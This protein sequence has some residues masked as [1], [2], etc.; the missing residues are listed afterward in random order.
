MLKLFIQFEFEK[1]VKYFKTKKLAK[2]ITGSLFLLVFLFIS[3]GIYSFFVTG[4]RYI[5]IES[6]ENIRSS[7]ILFLYEIFLL[8]ISGIIVFSTMI[9]GVFNLFRGGDN[10]W[11]ISSP[12]Y[13]F[14]P[15][16]IFIR[17]LF[18]STLPLIIM[19]IPAVAALVKVYTISYVGVLAILLSVV[20][21]IV[22]LNSLT[23]LSV[24]LV[25]SLYSYISRKIKYI[26][27]NLKGL[28]ILLLITIS[29]IVTKVW[30]AMKSVDLISLFKAKEISGTVSVSNIS[31]HFYLLPTHSF[32]LEILHWQSSQIMDAYVSFFTLFVVSLLFGLLWWNASV[33]FYPLWKKLQ[34][35]GGHRTT[36]NDL[37]SSSLTYRFIGSK[38]M[39]LFKKEL[40]ITSRNYKGVMWFSFLLF[41][42]LLQI[43]ANL[44]L[45]RNIH[46][47]EYDIV[48][49]IVSL[50]LIQYIIAIYFISSFTL[51]FVFPSFSV[52]KKTSWIL[53]SS[54]LSFKKIF[55]GKYFFYTSFFVA[56]GIIMNYINS[57]IL[58]LP[59]THL[60]YSSSLFITAIL[61]IVTL[62]LSLGA[63]FPNTETDDPEVIS[64]SMPGLFFTA[65]ALVY[66]ALSDG[67][68][69]LC[70]SRGMYYIAPLFMLVT[71]LCIVLLI[72]QVLKNKIKGIL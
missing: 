15:K 38:T 7:L 33:V 50:Q 9:T 24:L 2:V 49:K 20:F 60:L 45:G 48:Q 58:K 26:P 55:F 16:L 51:R 37:A 35:E 27:F 72:K 31:D 71:L 8:I 52:E 13:S 36:K 3:I 67:V 69:Y 61:F 54:P 5:N 53:S 25:A 12:K 34:E 39:V 70:L 65:L 44:I 17:S 41:I 32:A 62:G 4:F 59:F 11:I 28:L 63:L 21:L 64:T 14:L 66:G 56:L 22:T 6:E 30:S 42:W 18:N 19:F 1:A 40:L 43:A 47:H 10:N 68:L 29:I 46:Q 57:L 23:L